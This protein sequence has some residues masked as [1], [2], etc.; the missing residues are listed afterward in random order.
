MSGAAVSGEFEGNDSPI[1]LENPR[2]EHRLSREVSPTGADFSSSDD[3]FRATITRETVIR[4]VALV[5]EVVR[6]S[7][8]DSQKTERLREIMSTVDMHVVQCF[9]EFAHWNPRS[10]RFEGA[11]NWIQLAD[12]LEHLRDEHSGQ[13][14]VVLEL[15]LDEDLIE[16]FAGRS[17]GFMTF[18]EFQMMLAEADNQG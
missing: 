6:S 14:H 9:I 1:H 8:L 10:G 16:S 12:A 17:S 5:L 4:D 13:E 11:P 18:D 7:Q 15:D 2:E 3:L